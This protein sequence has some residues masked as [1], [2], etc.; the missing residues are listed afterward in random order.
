MRFEK[1]YIIKIS[2]L[3][4]LRSRIISSKSFRINHSSQIVNNLYY[5]N[6]IYNSVDQNLLGISDRIKYRIR[7]YGN[8][9][10]VK[11][12]FEKKCRKD[13]GNFKEGNNAIVLNNNPWKVKIS[14]LPNLSELNNL[15]VLKINN[16]DHLSP[17][18]LNRYKREYFINEFGDRL[19]IDRD[20]V[21]KNCRNGVT[22]NDFNIVVEL[23]YNSE[24]INDGLI[25]FLI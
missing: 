25:D 10:E 4:K 23:K 20:I 19:T 5:D 3:S 7:W 17:A 14:N 16:S 21:Y 8:D 13:I 11:A 12:K 22:K 1:K 18:L 15:N 9:E 24:K 2:Q 6:N